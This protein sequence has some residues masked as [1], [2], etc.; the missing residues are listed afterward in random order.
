MFLPVGVPLAC[1]VY[2]SVGKTATISGINY[3]MRINND[4][5]LKG[6]NNF[7]LAVT[8]KSTPV[9]ANEGKCASVLTRNTQHD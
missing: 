7:V 3:P 6:A 4:F 2:Q 8:V 5:N 9:Y 1:T